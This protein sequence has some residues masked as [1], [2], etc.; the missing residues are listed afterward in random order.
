MVTLFSDPMVDVIN[1]F[2]KTV[3]VSPFYVS[4]II[5]PLASN[6]SEVISAL[7][8][9]KKKTNR[10]LS[11]TISSLYGAATMNNTMGLAIFMALVYFRKLKWSFSAE[12]IAILTVTYVVGLNGLRT[13]LS[14][15]QAVLVALMFPL[16]LVLVAMLERAGLD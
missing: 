11:L 16:S 2:G 13:T 4:F 10:A 3:G 12:V 1:N 7:V 6:A 9:A 15:W 14:M 8:F 5:T